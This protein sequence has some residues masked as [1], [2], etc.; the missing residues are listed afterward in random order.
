VRPVCVLRDIPRLAAVARSRACGAAHEWHGANAPRREPAR[1]GVCTC[2][3]P[4][5]AVRA[6]R[7]ARPGADWLRA[8]AA[9]PGAVAGAGARVRL[10]R[11]CAGRGAGEAGARHARPPGR[12]RGARRR[13]AMAPAR[14]RLSP[15]LWVVTAAAAAT[16]VSAGRGEGERRGGAGA[17]AVLPGAQLPRLD[18]SQPGRRMAWA[19]SEGGCPGD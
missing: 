17:G 15:A 1:A 10:S 18:L 11:V 3:R 4:V 5:A 8:G 12:A 13:P 2:C 6:P 7:P 9:P 19:G 16:C 14:A